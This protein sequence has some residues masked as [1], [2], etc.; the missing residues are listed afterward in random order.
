MRDDV[1]RPWVASHILDVA[2]DPHAD[3]RDRVLRRVLEGVGETNPAIRNAVAD[4]RNV[5]SDLQTLVDKIHQRAYTVTDDDITRLQAEY[6]D[7]QLFEI[8][9]SAAL[10]ASRQRLMAGLA[11]LDEA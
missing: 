4:R 8:I 9:V 11:A 3:L 7:D 2:T 5:P 1:A 6:N 10:G